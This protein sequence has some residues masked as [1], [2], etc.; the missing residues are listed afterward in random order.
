MGEK[1]RMGIRLWR[2]SRICMV[3][4]LVGLLVFTTSINTK[5]SSLPSSVVVS[6]PA[7]VVGN[8]TNMTATVGSPVPYRTYASMVYDASDGYTVLFG[9]L[10]Y[11]SSLHNRSADYP[12]NDTWMLK[13]G[14]WTQIHTSISPPGRWSAQM[15]Y[16]SAD[17]YVLLFGGVAIKHANA[18]TLNDTWGY[19]NG[20]W[21]NLTTAKAPV[22]RCCGFIGFDTKDNY[23]VLFGGWS[24]NP[25]NGTQYYYSD[26][27]LFQKGVWT[28]LLI[29]GPEHRAYGQITYDQKDG[30]LLLFGGASIGHKYRDTWTFSNGTWN[31]ISTTT[32][33]ANLAMGGL[34]YI[35]SLGT[36]MLYGNT[37]GL[38]HENTTWIYSGGSWTR[39][40][41]REPSIYL[42]VLT[43]DSTIKAV[44]VVSGSQKLVEEPDTWEVS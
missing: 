33:P 44:I 32:S 35:P 22:P 17:G 41:G 4:L 15:A 24:V 18:V 31:K 2:A 26:T 5:A 36:T 8:W 39:P 30:Y 10:Y 28:K 6:A 16:D 34:V 42:P 25:R 29:H 19:H 23:T 37:G 3:I 40:A 20:T 1:E 14:V 27:W 13:S 21:I 9:G 38:T 7:K 12:M 43:Y 11:N